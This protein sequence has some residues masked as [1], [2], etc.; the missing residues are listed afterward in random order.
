MKKS[1][2]LFGAEESERTGGL[3]FADEILSGT[4]RSRAKKMDLKSAFAC[5][6]LWAIVMKSKKQTVVFLRLI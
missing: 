5:E 6:E 2:I 1:E 3:T 4:R